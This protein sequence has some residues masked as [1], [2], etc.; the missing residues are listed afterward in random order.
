VS[1][2]VVA[3][4]SAS[5]ILV[6]DGSA[7]LETF[8]VRRHAQSRVAPSAYVFPGGTVRGDDIPNS[9]AALEAVARLLGERSNSP[10]ATAE[11]AAVYAAGIRELF[12]EAGVLLARAA[13]RRL[14]EI[15]AQDT[16]RQERLASARLMVQSAQLSMADLLAEIGARPAYECLVPFSHWVTPLAAPARFD[17][18]FFMAE[19]PRG[20][21]ALHCTIETT[22]GVWVTPREVLQDGLPVVYATEQHLRRLAPLASVAEALDFARNKPIRRVQPELSR[23]D[24]QLRVW[25]APGLIDSW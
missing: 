9:D 13:D 4:L 6:R 15:D 25:L 23:A 8:M 11:A 5:V 2:P 18:R 19:M 7:G 12:E 10:I 22:E 21:E 20:Q 14:L 17:T 16:S 3:R 24:G 1:E